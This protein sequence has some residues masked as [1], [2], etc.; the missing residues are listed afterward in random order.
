MVS[1]P[2]PFMQNNA[3]KVLSSLAG[4]RIR[5]F[6]TRNTYLSPFCRSAYI[7]AIF[8]NIT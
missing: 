7:C 4:S 6:M 2:I 5:G 1:Q 3:D 8:L